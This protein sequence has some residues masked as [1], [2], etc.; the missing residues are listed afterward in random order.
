MNRFIQ[1]AVTVENGQPVSKTVLRK[2]SDI[3]TVIDRTTY[4]EVVLWDE[5]NQKEVQLQVTNSL[6]SILL[7]SSAAVQTLVSFT[8]NATSPLYAGLTVLLNPTRITGVSGTTT[9]GIRYNINLGTN[10]NREQIRLTSDTAAATTIAAIQQAFS[11]TSGL[12]RRAKVTIP[13]ASLKNTDITN[14]VTLLPAL[15]AGF[16]YNVLSIATKASGTTTTVYAS[17]GAVAIKSAGAAQNLF[18][19]PANILTDTAANT[20]WGK[21]IPA[22]VA[23]AATLDQLVDNTDI[24][25]IAG[26][27]FT[28]GTFDLDVYLTYEVVSSSL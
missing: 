5:I 11:I 13:S 26:S 21:G 3:V 19:L 4:R 8:C 12:I 15:G 7:Q 16:V 24:V 20:K 23:G 27:S 17:G 28:T 18:S 9:T 22:V 14:G 10:A 6:S 25:A 1:L 2:A